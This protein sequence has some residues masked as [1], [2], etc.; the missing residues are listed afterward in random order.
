M[1]MPKPF[2]NDECSNQPKTSSPKRCEVPEEKTWDLTRIFADDQAFEKT[3]SQGEE[4][5][6]E[7]SAFKG[8]LCSSGETLLS[9]FQ[10]IEKAE[11]QLENLYVYA[12]MKNDQDTADS[13]YSGLQA[14]VDQFFAQY[15]AAKAYY[16][17]ELSAFSESSFEELVKETPEL[18]LYRHHYESVRRSQAHILPPEQ[19]QLLARASEVMSGGHT[20]F[21]T[22]DNADQKFPSIQDEQGRTVEITHGRFGQLIESRDRRVRRETFQGLYKTYAQ[23]RNTYA[24]TLSINV[25]HHNVNAEIHHFSSAREAAL[26]DNVIPE[27]VYDNLVQAVNQRI[28]LL[29]RYTALRKKLLGLDE[30]HSYDLYVP[31]VKDVDLSFTFQEAQD[32]ILEATKPLGEDY[33]YILKTAFKERWID[34][35]ENQGKRSGAYS[36]GSY[37]SDP[38]ILMT[39]KGTLDD[40]YTL[41][42]ELGHSCHSWLTRRNQPF[43]YGDYPIFLAEIA[44]TTNENLLTTYL[45]EK[46]TEPATRR[47]IL[48]KYLD[49]FKGTVFRQTQFAEFEHLIHQADQ[50]G[51][52]LT[53]D[54]L[55]EQYGELNR[56]YYGEALTFDPEIALE[57]AR[58]PH[59]Y[60]NYYVYQY[61]TGFSAATAFASRLSQRESAK[62][63]AYLHYL[64]SGSSDYPI[65]ILKVAGLDMTTPEPVEA[66]LD[67]FESV[68]SEMESLTPNA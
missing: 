54:W 57:W 5:I 44:S 63:A 48:M 46:M 6:R 34:W 55:C 43:I 56:R 68:L 18:A 42:H 13:Y 7:I 65:D 2:Y 29:H 20:I 61:A 53:A 41:I 10:T 52:A 16:E 15:G 11:R 66:A 21:A 4:W 51:V 59:F 9:A 23:Y 33:Q 3:F 58:I 19:E 60:Y 8:K 26:F 32:I 14:R 22:L 31:V 39:W 67:R 47:A 17:P 28:G 36:G 40:L 49:G 38:Y 12:S 37:E 24:S 1:K 25:K 35:A 27:S 62:T 45:L 64:S 30:L 50:K